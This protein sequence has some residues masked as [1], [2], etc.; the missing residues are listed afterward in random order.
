M[1]KQTGIEWTNHTFNPWWGCTKVSPGC[2]NCYAERDS[3]RWGQEW[4]KGAPRRVFGDNHWKDPLH[5]NEQARRDGVRRRVFCASMADVFEEEAPVGQL[6][7]L[8]DL[9]RRTPNLDWQ[10]LTKRP[11]LIASKLPADWGQGFP[12]V[13]LG[14]SVEDQKRAEERI[15][16][17]LKVPA[18]I[19]FLSCEPLLGPVDLEDL[20]V[21]VFTYET[22]DHTD[23]ESGLVR[24]GGIDWVIAGGESGPNARPVHPDW[25]R[26]LRTQVEEAGAAFFFKQWGEW[27]P[28]ESCDGLVTRTEQT[29]DWLNETWHF[30]TITPR[31]AEEQVIDDEPTL[32]RVGK[33]LAGRLLDGVVHDGMPA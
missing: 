32:Y 31:Q 13:W 26:M 23:A 15:P 3:K 29:A 9:I 21:P 28:G 2:A 11:H 7:R 25:L 22:D 8:W 4:G 24:V 18:R 6:D 14:T 10:L 27:A 17:L 33:K 1:G 19:H 16:E 12:N 5:W 30:G 20:S